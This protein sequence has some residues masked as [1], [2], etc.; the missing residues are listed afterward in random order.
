MKKMYAKILTLAF[1]LSTIFISS[2]VTTSIVSE[3][4]RFNRFMNSVKS[5]KF[6][7]IP[8][9]EIEGNPFFN[10][11]FL[12]AK[13]ESATNP[14]PARYNMFTDSIEMINDGTIYE[15]PKTSAYS[16]ISFIASRENF[17]YLNHGVEANGYY[18][19]L[20]DGKNRLLKKLKTEFRDA[21]PALN[22]F[23]QATPARFENLPAE[24]F[25]QTGE[26]LVKIPRKQNEFYKI[27]GDNKNE[28]E[29]FVKKQKL[30]VNQELDLIRLVQFLN[31]Q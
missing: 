4:A 23:T 11:N 31:T 24:Y 8:Y 1:I 18:L 6:G 17:V 22:S 28:V 14:I 19:L 9:D 21:V 25:I 13:V 20:A 16:K 5:A 12:A 3:A 30:K 29:S 2:Q 10:K 27:F 7:S 15:L 26:N